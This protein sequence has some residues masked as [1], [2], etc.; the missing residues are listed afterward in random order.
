M[1]RP[2]HL[3]VAV[4]AHG[5]GHATQVGVV[6]RALRARLPD[7]RITV[8]SA[9]PDALLHRAMGGPIELI[10]TAADPGMA[11]ASAFEVL[12]EESAAAYAALHADW[13]E[14]VA[15]EAAHLAAL[16]PDLVLAD[17]P[18][19][20][21]A[22]AARARIPA[23][24]LCSLNW[25]DLYRHY[26]GHRP[27]AARIHAEIHAAYAAA[28]MFLVPEPGMPMPDLP[29]TRRI[30][31]CA[32]LGRDRRAELDRRLGLR[33]GSRLVLV[34]MGGVPLAADG[35]ARWPEQAD[36]HWII[37]ADRLPPRPDMTR[38]AELDLPTVDL[39]RSSDALVSKLGYSFPTECACNGTPLLYVPRPDWP[40]APYI[41]A[42]VARHCA[43]EQISHAA[44]AAGSFGDALDRLLRGPRPPMVAPSGVEEAAAILYDRLA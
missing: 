38:L 19:L 16:A 32:A 18:Y 37:Q 35:Y 25:A 29:N 7:L 21:L 12:V 20:P 33:P 44:F 36:T 23:I 14:R 34:S 9:L 6:V 40:E 10:P 8:R 17:V 30:G 5:Y 43:A 42:W 3:Y 39:L 11:M 13:P 41:E 24:A 1:E 28:E 22:A 26:C 27:E 2:R 31:P 4:T 15:R